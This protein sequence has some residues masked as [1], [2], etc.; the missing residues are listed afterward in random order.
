[1]KYLILLLFLTP[2]LIQAQTLDVS[3]VEV[4]NDSTVAIVQPDTMY[5]IIETGTKAREGRAS[6]PL[7]RATLIVVKGGQTYADLTSGIR[8]QRQVADWLKA[9]RDGW[10]EGDIKRSQA[11]VKQYQELKQAINEILQP[12]R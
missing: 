4:V 12:K 6:I 7:A 11:V 10:I 3:K 8:T 2:C 9:Q 5:F 1:M